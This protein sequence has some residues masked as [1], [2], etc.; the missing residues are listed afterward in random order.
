MT[1]A[2]WLAGGVVLHDFVLVPLT[3]AVCWLGARVLPAGRRAPVAAG[4]VVLGTL[5]L[6]AVP[7]LG[8]WGANSDNATILGRDYADGLAGG[9]HTDFRR[10]ARRA[11]DRAGGGPVARVLVVDDDPTVREV[12]VSYLRA[13]QHEVAGGGRRRVGRHD[14]AGH[15]RRPGRARPDAAR[16]RRA[17]GL[18]AAARVQRRPGHHADRA[19]LGDRPRRRARA[20]RR[21]LRDQAVQPARAGAAGRVGAAACRRAHP[22]R[23]GPPRRRRP[24]PSTWPGTRPPSA[25]GCWP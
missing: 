20:R 13:A 24:R 8:G 14:H 7:V 2:F 11:R 18:P 9:R 15:A 5:T 1:T 6:L 16:H 21:R 17:R 10:R 19:G 12:V 23:A 3:L 25:A 4:L 22:A